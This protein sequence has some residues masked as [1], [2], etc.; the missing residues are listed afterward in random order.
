MG[1]P[2][3]WPHPVDY[4]LEACYYRHWFQWT[5]IPV[6][7]KR[8]AVAWKQFQSRRPSMWEIRRLF[9]R[10]RV[11]TGVAV[12]GGWVSGSLAI[13]DFDSRHAYGEWALRNRRIADLCPTAITPRG[14][15]VYFR[16]WRP[17]FISWTDGELRGTTGQYTLLPPSEGPGGVR[18]RWWHGDPKPSDFPLLDLHEA[19]FIDAD[20]PPDGHRPVRRGRVTPP[21]ESVDIR[22][23]GRVTHSVLDLSESV[24]S[25]TLSA[26]L[27]SLPEGPGERNR[28][29]FELARRL[30]RLPHLMDAPAADVELVVRQ[31]FKLARPVIRTKDWKTSWLDFRNAWRNVRP[32]G[33]PDNAMELMRAAAAGELPYTAAGYGDEATRKLLAVCVALA[34]EAA[35]GDFHMSCRIAQEVCGFGCQMT[36]ARRLAAFVGAGLLELVKPGTG[37]TS[38]RLAT[39]YRV[40]PDRAVTVRGSNAG[41]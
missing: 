16:L 33:G 19:G 41:S 3:R 34:S 38:R 40:R 24:P 32:P 6:K 29:L 37:G 21:P 11:V 26:V 15:H 4:F 18:Y 35:G 28:S 8:S 9:R 10:P 30:K 2:D 13:R 23:S 39:I 27:D 31:R 14:L 1:H 36:A 22:T 20:H 5:V 25:G 7:E 17:A 12:V